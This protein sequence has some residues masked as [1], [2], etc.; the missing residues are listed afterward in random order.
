M[1]V[2]PAAELVQDRKFR[3]KF[4]NNRMKERKS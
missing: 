3:L 1:M 2:N 4:I